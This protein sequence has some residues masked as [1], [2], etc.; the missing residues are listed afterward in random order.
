MRVIAA[1]VGVCNSGLVYG[2]CIV[3][4]CKLFEL[5]YFSVKVG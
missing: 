2:V 1:V 4:G 5:V 3:C